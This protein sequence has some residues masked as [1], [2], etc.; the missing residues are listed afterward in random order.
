MPTG[1]SGR[2]RRWARGR[3][4]RRSPAPQPPKTSQKVPRNSAPMG[5]APWWVLVMAPFCSGAPVRRG[6]PR[7]ARQP[8]G[9]PDPEPTDRRRPVRHAMTDHGPDPFVTDIEAATSATTRSA[10]PLDRH[11]P[12]AHGRCASSPR[13]RSASRCTTTSTSSWGG[14][15]GSGLVEMGPRGRSVLPA[16]R[17]GRRRRAPR[18]RSWHNV[19]NTGGGPL[20]LYSI[21]APCRAP[22]R[23]G[24]PSPRP[25]PTPR[26][27][28]TDA[29]PGCRAAASAPPAGRW[30]SAQG[31]E[32]ALKV[33]TGASPRTAF[34]AS[35]R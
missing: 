5:A 15:G 11:A 34:A 28:T 1:R 4:A 26:S 19:T 29:A 8:L 3:S 33:S 17:R 32:D 18:R 6:A 24:S 14:R 31:G 30:V 13:R 25:T 10:D 20:R 16:R 2:R 21:Y 23:H 7:R 12:P 22:A 27:T 9:G 35:G